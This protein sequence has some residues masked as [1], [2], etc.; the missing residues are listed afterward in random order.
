MSRT[1]IKKIMLWSSPRNI[2]TA[3]ILPRYYAQDIDTQEDWEMAE[4]IFKSLSLKRANF[5]QYKRSND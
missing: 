4:L 5:N 3:L 1:K 2:S